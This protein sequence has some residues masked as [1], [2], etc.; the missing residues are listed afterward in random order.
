MDDQ[1][2]LVEAVCVRAVHDAAERHVGEA[3]D[4]PLQVVA[5][6]LVA[7]AH[8]GVGLDAR[9]A[10]LGDRV[11]GGLR[12]V[13]PGRADVRHQRHVHVA[14]VRAAH[15]QAELPDGLQEGKDLDVADRAA[16]LGDEDV[17]VVACEPPDPPLDLIGDVRDDLDGLSQVLTAPLGG[18]D[19][20]VDRAGGGVG[21]P[22]Q[23]LVDEPLVVAEVQVGLAAVVGNEDLA[24]LERVHRARIDVDVR[25]QL[26]DH[27]PEATLL[28]EPSEGCCGEALTER[29][30]HA[31]RHEDVFRHG[32]S[33]Y[34][35]R[36]DRARSRPGIGRSEVTLPAGRK[37]P[38]GNPGVR[39]R[40]H[41]RPA[42][43]PRHD[44]GPCS[45]PASPTASATARRRVHRRPA[46]TRWP[47]CYD[48]RRP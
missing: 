39:R 47:P 40:G 28:E 12:L 3:G 44:H 48:H 24:V 10:Q 14:D 31:T 6:R 1:R 23:V 16:H 41:G 5:D 42:A 9:A 22:R 8:D 20:R 18:D 46:S 30:R 4:L 35:G 17:H 15:V 27:D 33:I 11:L 32:A 26:L 34:P 38:R 13:L 29:T 21:V 19:S 36:A 2:N 25:I 43:A 37:T 45:C 7:P